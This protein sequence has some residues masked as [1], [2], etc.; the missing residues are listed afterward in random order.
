MIKGL[1]SSSLS[2]NIVGGFFLSVII[3]LI[4]ASLLIL[5]I[6][7]K[8]ILQQSADGATIIAIL[9]GHLLFFFLAE[10]LYRFML[11][12]QPVVEIEH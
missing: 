5:A 4:L 3:F 11:Q 8:D 12:Q 6:A 2:R 1:R 10:M 7:L 9:N